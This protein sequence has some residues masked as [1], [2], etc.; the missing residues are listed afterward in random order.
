MKQ[1]MRKIIN[2]LPMI[3]LLCFLIFKYHAVVN[4]LNEYKIKTFLYK[5]AFEI[6]VDNFDYPV[7]I[8]DPDSA[9]DQAAQK[10]FDNIEVLT[11]NTPEVY[12]L[13]GT[14]KNQDGSVKDPGNMTYQEADNLI[15]QLEI[16][17]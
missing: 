5:S 15:K 11:G 13:D 16:Q 7:F 9:G 6:V 8:L 12:F 1:I 4:D 3:L 2:E 10:A 17:I 14:L